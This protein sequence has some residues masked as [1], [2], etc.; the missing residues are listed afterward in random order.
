MQVQKG[1]RIMVESLSG[2]GDL[3]A[4]NERVEKKLASLPVKIPDELN[5]QLSAEAWQDYIE[6]ERVIKLH[7]MV[8]DGNATIV[9]DSDGFSRFLRIKIP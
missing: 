2:A 5:R 6:G 3:T 1:V 7:G 4:M 8:T 9:G